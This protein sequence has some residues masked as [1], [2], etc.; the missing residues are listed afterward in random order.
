MNSLRISVNTKKKK[1]WK[2]IDVNM[3]SFY[4]ISYSGLFFEEG[5]FKIDNFL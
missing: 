5:I 3:M 1:E 2:L 4:V